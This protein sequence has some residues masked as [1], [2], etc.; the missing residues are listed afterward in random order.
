M[1]VI[2]TQTLEAGIDLSFDH[3][4]RARPIFPSVVQAAGRANRHG[5]GV[6]STVVVF[7]YV[8]PDGRD[9]RSMVYRDAVARDETDR[10]LTPGRVLNEQDV[11]Q[12][13]QDYYSQVFER[14]N[15]TGALE[16]IKRAA[17]GTWSDLG[18]LEPFGASFPREPVFVPVAGTST[19]PELW[20]DDDTRVLLD[21]FHTSIGQL[22]GK[23]LDPR[24]YT[25]SF[26]DRKR[27]LNLFG[28]FVTALPFKIMATLTE[29]D[30]KRRVQ[31]LAD[32]EDYSDE[33]GL[34][35]WFLRDTL[36]ETVIW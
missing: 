3:I 15:Y 29:M 11:D 24:T 26:A 22:Y 33:L 1:I 20:L 12:A 19:Q 21:Q 31:R 14:N 36:E 35:A 25:T 30:P 23:F 27:F 13:L 9:S 2:A 7:D 17:Y 28:R 4:L 10:I 8:R 18:G 16:R 5:Q 34:A 32:P 6:Q